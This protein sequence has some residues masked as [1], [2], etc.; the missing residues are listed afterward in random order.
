MFASADAAN[1]QKLV[2]AGLV[3][4]PVTFA[5]NKLRDRRRAG[6]PEANITGL[7]DLAKPGVTV[8]LE[9][10]RR[11]RPATT[12]ARSWPPRRIAV[13]PK[14]LE[15]D[16]K[17]AL[18]KVTSGE[19]DA[20]RR[21]RHRRHGGRHQGRRAST[22]PDADQ[23]DDQLPDRGGQGDQEPGRRAGVRGLGSVGRGA[24]DAGGRRFPRPVVAAG[25]A[26]CG[27]RPAVLAVG[28]VA[29]VVLPLVGL[30]QR[31]PW[32]SLGADL[33][34]A[35][36]ARR[37][38]PVARSRSLGALAAVGRRSACRWR[39]CWPAASFPGRALV[40]ALVTLPM[41]LPPV[42][43]GIALLYAFGRRGFA[44]RVALRP[45]RLAARVHHRRARSSPRRSWPC[46]SS[47]SPPRRRSASM[48]RRYRGGGRH[49]RRRPAYRVPAGDP[50]RRRP[51]ARGRR[52]ADLGPG[53]R[54]VRR[55]HHLR[56]QHPRHAPRPLP[57]ARLPRHRVRP[58]RHR[59]S[60]CPWCCSRV[61][62]ARARRR[63]ATDGSG[64]P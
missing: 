9:A 31:A 54:R 3:E 53:P 43:G 26:D 15:T 39:G 18:A 36:G 5:T 24:E 48:D 40:R 30:L 50:A 27:R 33:A 4:T 46:R 58:R 60:R 17:S 63:S 61:S 12:P 49:P 55:H 20:T 10:H 23:P 22:I 35:R 11:A 57:L 13:T 1:M 29:L 56:R 52:R 25:P 28:A 32:S 21:L 45:D 34:R 42:V 51:G 16:V 47:S 62:L 64:R 2:T 8:V 59:A 7:A 38:A 37:A 14:S 44:G 6:Q 19:A 41:V